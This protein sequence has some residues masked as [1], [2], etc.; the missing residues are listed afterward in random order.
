M[1]FNLDKIGAS[2]ARI[3]D[4]TQYKNKEI[5]SVAT[6][7]FDSDTTKTFKSLRL[8]SGH[9]QPIPNI[10]SER[11]CNLVVGASGS[12]KSRYICEWVKEY[13]K[14]YKKNPIYLFSSLEEDE[15]LEPIKPL[16]MI[17]D[18]EF[19]LFESNN[20]DSLVTKISEIM[21]LNSKTKAEIIKKSFIN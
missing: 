10:N 3:K 17:L 13:K 6:D 15:S 2:I 8:N 21:N 20:V 4:N 9:F 18:N 12:G 1:S 19:L 7:D 5:V 16:R 14:M 11:S